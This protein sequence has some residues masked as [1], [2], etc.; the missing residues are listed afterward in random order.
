MSI[1][2]D[3]TLQKIV[4]HDF[5]YDPRIYIHTYIRAYI[6]KY[7]H[8]YIHKYIR[9]YIHTHTH[10]HTNTIFTLCHACGLISLCFV[11]K[12]EHFSF[13]F[14]LLQMLV[15]FQ[16]QLTKKQFKKYS[17]VQAPILQSMLMYWCLYSCI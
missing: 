14:I 7:I 15:S 16:S 9:T 1:L 12:I 3:V 10:T 11:K 8:T 13:A 4:A 17:G 6:H 2:M 5:R